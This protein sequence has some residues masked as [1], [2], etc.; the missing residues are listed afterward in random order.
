VKLSYKNPLFPQIFHDFHLFFKMIPNKRSMFNK[1]HRYLLDWFKTKIKYLLFR[2]IT[3]IYPKIFFPLE[4]LVF[5]FLDPDPDWGKVL[6]P[7]PDP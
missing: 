5:C 3:K 4:K 2:L 1:I 6:D 7:D